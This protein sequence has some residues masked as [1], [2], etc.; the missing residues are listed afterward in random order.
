MAFTK[1]LLLPAA[2]LLMAAP[3]QARYCTP[4]PIQRTHTTPGVLAGTSLPAG[5]PSKSRTVLQVKVNAQGYADQLSV[6]ASS[7]SRPLD[8]SAAMYIGQFWQWHSSCATETQ[9]AVEWNFPTT[10][11]LYNQPVKR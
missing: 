2:C 7:G 8:E 3:A 5:F 4:Q 9:V 10:D 11:A 1:Y 6:Q